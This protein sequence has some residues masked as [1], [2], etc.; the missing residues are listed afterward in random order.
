MPGN[1]SVIARVGET[2]TFAELEGPLATQI[3]KLQQK[4]YDLKRERLDGLID[5]LLLRQ[6][7]RQKGLTV[8]QYIDSRPATEPTVTDNE[9]EEFYLRNQSRWAN[10]K[11]SLEEFATA[12]GSI[13]RPK[14]GLTG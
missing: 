2:I 12:S 6:A 7:A 4:I 10:W 14:K 5:G 11:G 13:S 9:V 8:Q 3:Y 1:E